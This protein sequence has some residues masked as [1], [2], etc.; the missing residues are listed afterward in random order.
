MARILVIN[1]NSSV[2][3]TASMDRGLD[4]LRTSCKDEIECVTLPEGPPGIETQ[5]DI[6]SVILPLSRLIACQKADAYV[7]ACFSD[8]GLALAREMSAKPVVGIAESSFVMALGLGYRF[9]IISIL[10]MSIPRHHRYVRQTGFAERL[11][12][13]RAIGLG[14]T[15][16]EGGEVI[17]RVVEV[18][19]RLR[20]EDRADVLILGCAGMGHWRPKAEQALG[21]PVIDP[22]QAAVAR[23]IGMVALGYQRIA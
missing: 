23:A 10:D 12:G 21:I 7:I 9:G 17:D 6:E 1:P 2:S 13:D 11:A 15:E 4:P 16:L 19:R 3:V 5:A 22:T 8:P 18:G 14:V 20:D